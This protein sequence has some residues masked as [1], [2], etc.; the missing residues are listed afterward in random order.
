MAGTR[1]GNLCICMYKTRAGAANVRRGVADA[2][3]PGLPH[4]SVVATLPAPKARTLSGSR[5]TEHVAVVPKNGSGS[6]LSP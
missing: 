3:R 5:R 2:W 4:A 1:D 6:S